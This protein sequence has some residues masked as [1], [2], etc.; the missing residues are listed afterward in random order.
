[1]SLRHRLPER[2]HGR[3][4]HGCHAP[5]LL[6][7]DEHADPGG[8]PGYRSDNRSRPGQG[9]APHRRRRHPRRNP[10]RRSSK[11]EATPSSAAS[12]PSTRR[13]S[14]P[15]PE[16]SRRSMFLA[17]TASAWTR[18]NTLKASSRRITTRSSPSSSCTASNRAEAISKM[19]RALEPVH[20]ARDRNL[21]FVAPGNLQGRRFP[22]RRIRHRLHGTLSRKEERSGEVARAAAS[23]LSALAS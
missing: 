18:C 5:A 3:V 6:H 8:A 13:S 17:A 4:P 22:R 12:T 10:A 19:E 14:R 2:R 1:M 11:S 7:R 23:L 20:R 9:P 16:K 21:D 15:R